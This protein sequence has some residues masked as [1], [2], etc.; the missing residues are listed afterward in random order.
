MD[1]QPLAWAKQLAVIAQNGLTY[2]RDAYDRE[3]YTQIQELAAEMLA[4][5]TDGVGFFRLDRLP[6]LSILRVTAIQIARFFDHQRHPE[7]PTDFD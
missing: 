6:E 2:A 7:W 1:P 4:V 5:G 3:H